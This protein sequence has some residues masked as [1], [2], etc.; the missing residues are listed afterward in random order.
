MWSAFWHTVFFDPIYNGLIFIAGHLPHADVGVAIILL[1][2]IVKVI[3]LPLSI[4]AAHT[5]HAMRSIE[6]KLKELKELHKDNREEL[7]RQTFA[8]YK[9]A[10]I[11]PF[12]SIILLLLQIPVVIALYMSVYSGGGVKLPAINEA[13]LYSFVAE[14]AS[15]SMLF[16]GFFDIAG[17]SIVLAVLAG[18]TQFAS[19]ALSLPPM[20][21]KAEG[22]P[23]LKEDLARSMQLQM[24]YA[25]PVIITFV[26][27]SVPAAVALYFVTSNLMTIVQEFVV[28][29]RIPNRH[30]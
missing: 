27:Y 4:K 2:V 26:A 28:R 5:Q 7:G 15:L 14:P 18:A 19:G 9:E 24:K 3:L 17:R 16:L 21:P 29:A 25:M 1:T 10:G 13:I 12:A 8:A 30:G 20:K 23:D 22:A 6:P 11:N